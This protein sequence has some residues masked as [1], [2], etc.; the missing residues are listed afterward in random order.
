[1]NAQVTQPG[2]VTTLPSA[3]Q[4]KMDS[5]KADAA[6]ANPVVADAATPPLNN[7]VTVVPADTNP[8]AAGERITLTREELNALRADAG[9]TASVQGRL[10]DATL[11]ME[12][13][14]HRLTELQASN[15][16][17]ATGNAQ[18]APSVSAPASTAP[19]IDTS[20]IRFTDEEDEQYGETRGY[21][22]KVA[23][24]MVAEE[25]NKL[26]P[27]IQRDIAEARTEAGK[28]AGHVTAN[29][30][31][32]FYATIV[33]AVPNLKEL[34]KHKHWGDFLDEVVPYT[35]GMT[36]DAVLARNVESGRA[37]DVIAIYNKF[38]EKYVDGS[39]TNN[40]GYAGAAPGG[41]ATNVPADSNAPT[42]KLKASDRKKAS[43]DYKKGR[44]AW[45]QLEEVNKKFNEADKAG[46]IDYSA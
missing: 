2:N 31:K 15:K 37:D 8:A 28:V 41:G 5:L 46:N 42:A 36:F 6:A 26:L 43:D 35:G 22:E 34:V 39:G 13:M 20:A 38:A 12:E 1:M 44:I 7:P 24:L 45:D 29:E 9:K 18:A 3:M 10:D 11:R 19:A 32:N 33:A 27:N 4:H 21:I 25:L 30:Q 40:A 16:A 23:R 17:S 14:A